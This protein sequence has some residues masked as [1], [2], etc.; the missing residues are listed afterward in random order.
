VKLIKTINHNSHAFT[1]QT[2]WLCYW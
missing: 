1:F 2:C